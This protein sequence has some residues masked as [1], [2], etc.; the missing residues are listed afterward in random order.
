P[1]GLSLSER[2][3]VMHDLGRGGEQGP[4]NGAPF[5]E[6]RA[7]AGNH[8]VVLHRV[9]PHQEKEILRMLDARAHLH[10][11]AAPVAFDEG[12]GLGESRFEGLRLAGLHGDKGAFQ[13][14][15]SLRIFAAT[16][17]SFAAST[18]SLPCGASGTPSQRGT[19]WKWTWNT[20]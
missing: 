1:A 6:S 12:P 14:H 17:S 20:L 18:M 16:G 3:V 15:S 10:L 2:L 11:A 13:D 5:G 7:F 8:H 9:P 4:P 19:I